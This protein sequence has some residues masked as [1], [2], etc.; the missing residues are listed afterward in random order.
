MLDSDIVD[1]RFDFGFTSIGSHTLAAHT[2]YFL[3]RFLPLISPLDAHLQPP[4]RLSFKRKALLVGVEEN[5]EQPMRRGQRPLALKGPHKDIRDMRQFL[6]SKFK[7]NGINISNPP[8]T[9][10]SLALSS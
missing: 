1:D 4:Q 7:F 2:P 6:I 5:D 9:A 8:F 10:R 3:F